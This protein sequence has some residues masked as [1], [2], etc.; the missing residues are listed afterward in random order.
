MQIVLDACSIINLVNASGLG[1][2]AD[3]ENCQLL[4]GP[5]VFGECNEE[6]AKILTEMIATGRISQLEDADIPLDLFLGLLDQHNLG[7]GETECIT[8][9][10]HSELMVCSDDGRARRIAARYRGDSQIVGSARLL[11]WCVQQGTLVCT[12][13]SGKFVQMKH[14]GG[15]LPDLPNDFFCL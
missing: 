6:P 8:A 12:D 2:C 1:A 9:A 7:E 15:F 14:C 5:I 11:Q 13:A 10:V 4:V 3:L